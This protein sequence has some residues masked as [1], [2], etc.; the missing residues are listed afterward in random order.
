M[1]YLPDKKDIF[2]AKGITQRWRAQLSK[3]TEQMRSP[4]LP[5]SGNNGK[6]C[7][8]RQCEV[9][10]YVK[11]TLCGMIKDKKLD[12]VTRASVKKEM[13][14]PRMARSARAATKGATAAKGELSAIAAEQGL[15]LEI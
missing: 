6:L 4:P 5:F 14:K 10:L 11:I 1:G 2:T 8:T 12:N 13:A 7:E 15:G 3:V 9:D